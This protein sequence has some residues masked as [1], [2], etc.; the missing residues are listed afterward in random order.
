MI[1]ITNSIHSTATST[2]K[3]TVSGVRVPKSDSV[4]IVKRVNSATLLTL[5]TR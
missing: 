1:R 3:E 5:L 4:V 2:L